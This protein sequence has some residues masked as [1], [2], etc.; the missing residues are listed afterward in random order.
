MP[1]KIEADSHGAVTTLF[2]NAKDELH[3]LGRNTK[4]DIVW[5]SSQISQTSYPV[6]LIAFFPDVI[7]R[8]RYSKNP[9]G[10]TDIAA[11]ALRMLQHAQPGFHL[12]R[13]DLIIGCV[14]HSRTSSGGQGE[15]PTCPGCLLAATVPYQPSIS[16]AGI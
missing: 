4:A 3:D 10:L 12:S 5:S 11:H 2:P 16:S 6:L 13:L 7:E 14:A 8:P 1:L 9:A 15:Y